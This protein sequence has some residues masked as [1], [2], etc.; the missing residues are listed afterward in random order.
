MYEIEYYTTDDGEDII[1]KYID[2]MKD[3]KAQARILVRIKRAQQGNFGDNKRLTN[4]IWELR[5]D[6]GK[7][8]RVYYSLHKNK[9]LLL[10][11]AGNKSSQREDI[12]KAIQYNQNYIEKN[13][14]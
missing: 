5:I 6:V 8:Y 2:G 12:K 10:L 3:I 13:K 9:I 11:C 4:D 14:Y 7:A 1:G